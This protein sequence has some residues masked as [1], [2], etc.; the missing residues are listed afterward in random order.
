VKLDVTDITMGNAGDV[1]AAGLAAIESGDTAFDLSAV[2]SCDSS[3]V[4]VLL[5]WRRAAEQRNAKLVLTGLPASL[6]S[7]ADVYGVASLLGL[8]TE[9]A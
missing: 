8:Q 4:A 2:G 3:A 5:A 7:I 1:A 6:V 9:G